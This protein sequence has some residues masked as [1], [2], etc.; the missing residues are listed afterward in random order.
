MERAP[1]SRKRHPLEATYRST[2]EGLAL[3]LRSLA[4]LLRPLRALEEGW[5][6]GSAACP[7]PDQIGRGGRGRVGGERGRH[8]RAGSPARCGT[9]HKAESQRS[10]KG[11]GHSLEEALGRSRGGLSTKVHLACDGKGRP[12]SVVLTPGQR[13]SSTQLGSVL[14]GI[15]VPRPSGIG[16]PRKRP[17]HLIA[18]KGYD[19]PSCRELMR[20][21]AIARTIPERRDRRERRAKHPGRPPNFDAS[22]YGRRNV[23]ERC[24]N[25]LK[26]WRGI[27][28]R[29]EKRALNYR[30]VV[31]I[32]AL[33]IWLAS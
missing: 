23:V 21:R 19:F 14:D 17:D 10:K 12:L 25:R 22:V 15:R 27:A 26:H 20:K 31:V 13:H 24:V 32:A 18:D 5:H 30:A 4:D 7:R 2:V 33:I 16:R 1:Q 29:Y 11:L 6:L 3:L 8:G 28:T 9:T